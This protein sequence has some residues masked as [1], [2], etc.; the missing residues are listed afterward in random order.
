MS[1]PPQ[2]AQ[3]S[4]AQVPPAQASEA[5]DDKVLQ[6]RGDGQ[7][8]ARISRRLG[9]DRGADAQRAFVRAL[10]RLPAS[11]AKEVRAEE[12]SRLDRLAERI[13]GDVDQNDTDR[14]RRLKAIERMRTE[15]NQGS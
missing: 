4:P 15:I 5:L 10:N 13:R 7:A 9:L 1:D 12:M 8:Y 3:V 11:E 6:L 2:P 14:D